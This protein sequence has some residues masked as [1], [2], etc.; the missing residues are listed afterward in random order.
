MVVILSYKILVVYT[1]TLCCLSKDMLYTQA[2]DSDLFFTAHS[3]S[4]AFMPPQNLW[5]SLV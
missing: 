1:F 3:T 2:Q 4:W 5:N